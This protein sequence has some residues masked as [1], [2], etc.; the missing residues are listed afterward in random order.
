MKNRCTPFANN[1][2][3]RT[4]TL[5]IGPIRFAPSPEIL[6]HR[7]EFLESSRSTTT[8]ANGLVRIMSYNILAECHTSGEVARK[9]TFPYC[10]PEIL[11]VNYRIQLLIREI[12]EHSVDVAA[13]QE[14][15]AKL[16]KGSF[17]RILEEFGY[18]GMFVNK[19]GGSVE[20]CAIFFK[21]SR[22]ELLESR[23][24][25]LR[26]CARI[27]PTG[28]SMFEL[29]PPFREL[30]CERLGNVAQLAVLRDCSNGKFRHL[31]F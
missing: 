8:N 20:G 17:R 30:L 3:G 29:Y 16:F 26:E 27:N 5:S 6:L 18:T 19:E 14:C 12:V 1:S 31:Q 22:F 21:K 11:D 10:R 7:R 2:V 9:E 4:V 25:S 13:L 28:Q 15:D 24:I 23:S